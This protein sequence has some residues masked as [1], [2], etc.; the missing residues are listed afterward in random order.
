MANEDRAATRGRVRRTTVVDE[1]TWAAFG[2]FKAEITGRKGESAVAAG[3]LARPGFPTL[4]DA[5]LAD[6]F[7][8]TQIDHLVCAADAIL[9]IETKTYA[10]HITDTRHSGE[11]M[12]HL[13][14]GETHHLFQNPVHQ[15][16]RHC[17]A[18]R[19]ALSGL[20]VPIAGYV[21]SAGSATFC[22]EL[23]SA[24]VPI[25]RLPELF[26]TAWPL[27]RDAVTLGRAWQRLVVAVAAAEPRREEHREAMRRR[28]EAA[29]A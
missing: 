8:V 29:A 7:G 14:E 17:R 19:S 21:V 13:A 16:H 28:R 9:V 5:L 18:V 27:F 24:V 22:A 20:D 4:H 15:N 6:V 2:E 3:V 25:A 11:W 1:R 23:A 10:G 12:Q 26:H